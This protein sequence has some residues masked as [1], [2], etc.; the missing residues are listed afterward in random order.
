MPKPSRPNNS[1]G[2]TRTAQKDKSQSKPALVINVHTWATPL[3]GII[4]LIIG[5]A[6][7]YF[8]RPFLPF[9]G[10]STPSERQ[11]QTN[12]PDTSPIP[13]TTPVSAIPTTPPDL[14][15]PEALME[16]LISQT[17][18]FKGAADAPVTIIEFSDFK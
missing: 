14:S 6:A 5:L 18:H 3:V 8:G 7:G 11:T 17:R 12:D 1:S 2:V 15:S 16:L 10:S 4:M 13:Q 9:D